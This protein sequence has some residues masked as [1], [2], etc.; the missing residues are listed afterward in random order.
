MN[1]KKAKHGEAFCLM[2]YR[3]ENN[4]QHAEIL[5]NSRDG[6]TPFIIS[7]KYCEILGRRGQSQ[8]IS[9]KSD[10][11]VP[12]FKPP[13]DMRVF[14]DLTEKSLTKHCTEIINEYWD[15]GISGMP[16]YNERYETKEQAIEELAKAG[17]YELGRG[18]PSIEV[19]GKK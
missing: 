9:W 19:V 18:S 2:I 8:H 1:E 6:V 15:K 12:E 13:K 3:C 5:W 16:P 10:I 14:V 11:A 4:S 7:C 17:Q